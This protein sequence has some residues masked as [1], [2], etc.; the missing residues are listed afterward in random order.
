MWDFLTAMFSKVLNLFAK[1]DKD[2]E[3]LEKKLDLIEGGLKYTMGRDLI[4]DMKYYIRQGEIDHDEFIELEL[5]YNQYE[6]LGGNGLVKRN[7]KKVEKLP[8]K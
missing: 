2:I 6:A 3:R 4:K 7:F 1:R 8:V 5:H